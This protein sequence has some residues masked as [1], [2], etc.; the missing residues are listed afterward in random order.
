MGSVGLVSISTVVD[1]GLYG[2]RSQLHIGW[3]GFSYGYHNDDGHV[4]VPDDGPATTRWSMDIIRRNLSYIKLSY[5]PSWGKHGASVTEDGDKDPSSVVGCG[6]HSDTQ[7][8]FYTL[9]GRF[10]GIVPRKLQ[11]KMTYA[12]AVTLHGPNDRAILNAGLFPFRF[13][14]DRFCFGSKDEVDAGGGREN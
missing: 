5:G 3:R 2:A 13:D 10:L 8:F 12:A 6:Y 4:Y 7:E 11:P 9:D 14:I 1:K